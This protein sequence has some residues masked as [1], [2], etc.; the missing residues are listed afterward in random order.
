MQCLV[1]SSQQCH[2]RWKAVCISGKETVSGQ[3]WFVAENSLL[4]AICSGGAIPFRI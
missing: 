1:I 4:L 2:Q 3:P